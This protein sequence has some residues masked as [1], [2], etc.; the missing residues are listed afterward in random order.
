M[1][2]RPVYQ[3]QA[4]RVER[5]WELTVADL[6]GAVSLVRRLAQAEEY[7]RESIAFVGQVAP[8]SF[9]LSFVFVLPEQIDEEIRLAREA[10]RS[11]DRLQREAA[12]KSRAVV[13]RMRELGFSGADTAF[14]LDVS[15]QRVSQL[16]G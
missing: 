14:V 1:T 7:I 15:P 4:S 11:A 2:G 12:A 16:R 13:S 3:V 9:D 10:A 5:S 8:D 6:P